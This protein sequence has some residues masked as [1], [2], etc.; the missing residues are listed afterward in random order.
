MTLYSQFK[1]FWMALLCRVMTTGQDYERFHP[2][3]EK[4]TRR[5]LHTF[6]HIASTPL[7]VTGIF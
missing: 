6:E 7:T 2:S 1:P 5:K 4:M 3:N